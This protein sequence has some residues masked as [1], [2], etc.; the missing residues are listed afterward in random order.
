[1]SSTTQIV[2]ASAQIVT[3]LTLREND[4]YKRFH[5]RYNDEFDLRFGIVSSVSYNGSD[6]MIVALEFDPN[7]SAAPEIKVWASNTELQLFTATPEEITAGF[8]ELR[9]RGERGVTAAREELTKKVELL[10]QV[11]VILE[12]ESLGSLRSAL[13]VGETVDEAVQSANQVRVVPGSQF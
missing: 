4:V 8:R 9:E 7:S 3:I 1:M 13:V 2:Q 11:C 6:A 5:K 12:R 10:D